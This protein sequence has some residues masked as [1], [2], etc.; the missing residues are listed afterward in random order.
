[1][2]FLSAPTSRAQYRAERAENIV[3]GAAPFVGG[4]IGCIA[5][6]LA[7]VVA[8]AADEFA[9]GDSYWEDAGE[10]FQEVSGAIADAGAGFADG[11][12]YWEDA[13]E[14]FQEVVLMAHGAHAMEC[15]KCHVR[16]QTTKQP[17]QKGYGLCAVCR[18]QVGNVGTEAVAMHHL[19]VG[20]RVSVRS[21]SGQW[22]DAEVL[23]HGP[24][25]SV[26]VKYLYKGT[27]KWVP[28]DLIPEVIHLPSCASIPRTRFNG[29]RPVQILSQT[30][31]G[32]VQGEIVNI[33]SQGSVTV[34]YTDGYQNYHKVVSHDQI[35]QLIR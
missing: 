9:D 23:S 20:M 10:M 2:P 32:W 16:Y 30:L 18:D 17:G 15:K 28:R 34:Q 33:D 7:G 8:D 11:D 1:M 24:D 19:A 31:N 12:S 35:P 5:D 4:A 26:A 6:R 27:V 21:S 13:G 25:G 3:H 22:L 14:M 29:G